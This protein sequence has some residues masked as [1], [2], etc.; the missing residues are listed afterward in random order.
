MEKIESIWKNWEGDWM[1]F[2]HIQ[3][4]VDQ[5]DIFVRSKVKAKT[6]FSVRK[7]PSAF[8]SFECENTIFFYDNATCSIHANPFGWSSARYHFLCSFFVFV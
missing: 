5:S 8:F 3:F 7:A 4:K 6:T 1:K 2:L